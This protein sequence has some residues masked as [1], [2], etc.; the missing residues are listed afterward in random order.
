MSALMSVTE[1]GIHP[2]RDTNKLAAAT[3]EVTVGLFAQFARSETALN[4]D[5]F[6]IIARHRIGLGSS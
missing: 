2:V 3:E 6:S 5:G 1:K 4:D